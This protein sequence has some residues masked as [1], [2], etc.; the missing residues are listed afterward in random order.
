MT[1][2]I[3]FATVAL[4]VVLAL[5]LPGVVLAGERARVDGARLELIATRAVDGGLDLAIDVVLDAGYKTYWRQPGDSGVPPFFDWSASHNLTVA[6]VDHPYP[7]RFSD[8]YGTSLGHDAQ[9]TLP[10]RAT[11]VD[12]AADVK[13]AVTI[14]MGVCREICVPVR[15]RLATDL[16][17]GS[18]D[19][20]AARR[21]AAAR[22]NLP[23]KVEGAAQVLSNPSDSRRLR[24]VVAGASEMVVDGPP[25]WSLPLPVAVP[26][27]PLGTFEVELDGIPKSAT[28]S[29]TPVTVT[30]MTPDGPRETA[31]VLP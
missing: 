10:V 15:V 14:D 7:I 28:V 29:G 19:A 1:R 23:A 30:Y 25:E 9:V 17:V 31:A 8:G 21:V 13:V 18:H 4:L 22:A 6:G 2:L 26:G 24:V 16:P 11:P 20:G 12:P 5:S 27:A 3:A